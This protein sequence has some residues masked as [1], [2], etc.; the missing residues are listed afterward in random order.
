VRSTLRVLRAEWYRLVHGRALW[1]SALV[2]AIVS[3]LRVLAARAAERSTFAAAVQRAL[4]DGRELPTPPGPS[5]AYGPFVDA[6]SAG[7]TVG[8]M[9]LLIAASRT[10]AG[11]LESGLLRMASTRSASRLALAF[12][13]CL[14]GV[15]LCL[16]VIL[17]TAAGA[18]LA[19]SWLFAFGPVVEDGYELMSEPEL[20]AQLLMA[21]ATTTPSL[22]ATWTFGV[23]V[24]AASRS[25]TVAVG[26]ALVLYLGFDLFKEVLGV[27]RYWV[28]ASY[29]PS[30]VDNSYVKEVAGMARGFSDAGFTEAL[31]NQNLI[32]PWP[33]AVILMA[34]SALLLSRRSL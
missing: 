21:V 32:L 26:A 1:A 5:N 8:A 11:D 9:L 7:L 18:W 13:R 24:S 31:L 6:W 16:G 33:E 34:L 28:F 23:L 17:V 10:L 19:A 20:R 15:P 25:G 3:F 4:M 30:F 27:Q 12:G 2:L 22:I 29:N 14:L